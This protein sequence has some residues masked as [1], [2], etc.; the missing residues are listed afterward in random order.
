[1]GSATHV[2]WLGVMLSLFHLH[3][4]FGRQMS[5]MIQ[6]SITWRDLDILQHEDHVMS[7][8]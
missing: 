7:V 6:I 1:M 3:N 2:V 5:A 4:W 8:D